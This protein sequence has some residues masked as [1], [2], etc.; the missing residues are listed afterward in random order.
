[1]LPSHNFS[2]P[3]MHELVSY[4]DTDCVCA[5]KLLFNDFCPFKVSVIPIIDTVFGI[6]VVAKVF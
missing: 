5:I 6:E 4:D 2:D 1:M 3:I